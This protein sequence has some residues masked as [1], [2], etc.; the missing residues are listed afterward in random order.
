VKISYYDEEIE[1]EEQIELNLDI[2][3]MVPNLNKYSIKLELD[4]L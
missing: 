3:T 2:D 4:S 1:K